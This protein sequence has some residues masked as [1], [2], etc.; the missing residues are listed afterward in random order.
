M[1]QRQPN[2]DEATTN[3][4]ASLIAKALQELQRD[5]ASGPMMGQAQAELQA[6]RA[7][8][9]DLAQRLERQLGDD[10]DQ[11]LMLAGQLASLA[12]SLDKLVSHLEGLS[13]LMGTLLERLVQSPGEAA[14]P[15]PTEPTFAAGGE[16]VSLSLIAVP[17]FQ[18]LMDIQKALS[19]LEEV[20]GASVER[21][22]EGDSRMLVHLKGALGAQAIADALHSGTGFNFVVEESKPELARLRLKVVSG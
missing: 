19:G 2:P 14:P 3:H 13:G 7:A 6:T 9:Q 16:G 21:F 5:A 10:R 8:V 15:T 4:A 22:Q 20:A 17:G 1:T 12:G 11:R 18:A